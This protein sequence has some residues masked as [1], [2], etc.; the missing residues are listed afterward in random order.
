MNV[1]TDIQY[2][3]RLELYQTEKPYMT[4]FEIPEI[5]GSTTNHRYTSTKAN[6]QDAKNAKSLFSLHVNGFEFR[7]WPMEFQNTDFD[8]EA[9]IESCYYPVVLQQMKQAFPEA[10]EIFILSHL[11]RKR[12]EPSAIPA[13][14][15]STPK[16]PNTISYAHTDFS[17]HGAKVAVSRLIALHEHL[18]GRRFEILNVWR[19]TKGPNRD[20][21]LALC[22]YTS[23]NLDDVEFSDV[24]HKDKV[25]ESTRLYANSGH[26]WYY[27]DKQTTSEVAIFRNVD[28]RGLEYPFAMH[29]SFANPNVE[30]CSG[31]SAPPRE[32]IE[33]RF[34]L[35]Y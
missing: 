30:D 27:I 14:P 32:S 26:R 34:V 21:P 20:W 9:F 29:L 17:P 33:M 12:T 31:C 24:V 16:H 1:S 6:I 8:D 7:D 25:G 2:L 15:S 3:S 22:D 10:V 18:R 19:V 23:L 35:F 11:R 5:I 13:P 28:S 4:T